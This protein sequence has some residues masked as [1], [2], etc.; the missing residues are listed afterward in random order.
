MRPCSG[1]H[2]APQTRCYTLLR[3]RKVHLERAVDRVVEKVATD[4]KVAGRAEG[5]IG[6]A[7]SDDGD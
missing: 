2:A 6:V 7:P 3:A 4:A 5:R 1:M